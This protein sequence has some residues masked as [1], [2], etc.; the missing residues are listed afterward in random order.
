MGLDFEACL[1]VL[2]PPVLD[3][4]CVTLSKLFNLSVS[5]VSSPI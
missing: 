5:P 3:T 1:L 2:V 4:S